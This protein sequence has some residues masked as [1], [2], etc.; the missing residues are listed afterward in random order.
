M[1]HLA[2][3]IPIS[4]RPTPLSP[5]PEMELSQ[6]WRQAGDLPP[7][8]M[9]S[10]RVHIQDS[11]R[12]GKN[13]ERTITIENMI[14]FFQLKN[15]MSLLPSRLRLALRKALMDALCGVAEVSRQLQ[16]FAQIRV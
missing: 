3:P 9:H 13:I 12:K 10:A 4:T 7:Q 5:I 15:K 1:S 11:K 2:Y 6:D 16:K 14:F 8:T